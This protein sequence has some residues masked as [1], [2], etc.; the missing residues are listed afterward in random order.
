MSRVKFL[1][2]FLI[3]LSQTIFLLFYNKFAEINY[4]STRLDLI[5]KKYYDL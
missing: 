3:I 4:V 1:Y 2:I 5:L